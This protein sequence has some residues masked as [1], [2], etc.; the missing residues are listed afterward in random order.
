MRT[1]FLNSLE[2]QLAQT[3]TELSEQYKIQSSNA[4]R[5]LALTDNLREVED[6]GREDRDELG[7]LRREVEGLRERAK[8][9]KEVVSEKERQLIVRTPLP[10]LI[11][12]ALTTVDPSRRSCVAHARAQSAA[13][14]KRGSQD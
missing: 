12:A 9:H 2:A 7:K 11:L 8:W 6:R 10:R 14:P 5:L 3:R 13:P 4:Q 1:A